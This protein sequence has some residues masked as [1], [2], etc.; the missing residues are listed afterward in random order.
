MIVQECECFLQASYNCI[1]EAQVANATTFV[2]RVVMTHTKTTDVSFLSFL[3]VDRDGN[4]NVSK[5][6]K[7]PYLTAGFGGFFDITANAR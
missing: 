4:V 5:L 3:E 7:K 1:E 6:G 2:K